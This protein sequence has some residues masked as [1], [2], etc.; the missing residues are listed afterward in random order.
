MRA[1]VW[2][3]TEGVL[4]SKK[5]YLEAGGYALEAITGIRTV[6]SLNSE[7]HEIEQYRLGV[8]KAK[9]VL[10]KFAQIGGACAGLMWF[11][12]YM[13]YGLSL[14]SAGMLLKDKREN[15]VTGSLYTINE[16]IVTLFSIRIGLD[17]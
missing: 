17:S 3:I 13:T 9:Q 6:K 12:C 11:C 1:W 2:S 16:I 15:P 14:F 8:G 7:E 10:V 4:R 5:S